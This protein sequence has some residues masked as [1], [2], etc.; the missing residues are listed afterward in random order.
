MDGDLVTVRDLALTVFETNGRLVEAGNVLVR[1]AGL[2][3][4]WWRVL[5]A[6]GCSPHPLPVAHIARNMGLIRQAVQRVDDLLVTH[7]LVTTQPSPHHQRAKLIALTA[8]GQAALTGAEQAVEPLDRAILD[9]IG[10]QR[11]AVAIAALRE[12]N[13]AM[14]DYF[15]RTTPAPVAIDE[16]F[17]A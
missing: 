13:A 2:T 10:P 1:P 3:S 8:A 4:T 7:G 17:P 12:M 9:Q 5:G 11:L 16:E 6:P 15:A 14:G